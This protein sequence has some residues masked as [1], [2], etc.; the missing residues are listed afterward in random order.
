MSFLDVI[1]FNIA[2]VYSDQEQY[3]KAIEALE[4]ELLINREMHDRPSEA[5]TLHT[6]ANQ[7]ENLSQYSQALERYQQALVIYRELQNQEREVVALWSIGSIYLA[8]GQ[9]P[10]A[11]EQYQQALSI[12]QAQNYPGAEA[13]SLIKIGQ[14]YDAQGQ[15]A[16][17]LTQY[18]Q[19]LNTHRQIQQQLQ[20]PDAIDRLNAICSYVPQY[21]PQTS[22][23]L[24]GYSQNLY[25][26]FLEFSR[27]DCL[28]TSRYVESAALHSIGLVYRAQGRYSEAMNLLQ[29]SLTISVEY[30]DPSEQAPTLL[31]IGN[32][33][34][35]QGQYTQ[36]LDYYQ[37]A[38]TI[39]QNAGIRYGESVTLNSMSTVYEAQGQYAQALETNQQSIDIAR[40]I[41]NARLVQADAV[42][43]LGTTYDRLGQY[44]Q[45]LK[46][47]QQALTTYREIGNRNS[48]AVALDD[49][50]D[51]YRKQNQPDRA[52]EQ[53]QQALAIWQEIGAVAQESNTLRN[54]GLVYQM[55]GQIDRSIPLFQQAI[56]IQR[57][58]GA[59][60]SIGYTLQGLGLAYQQQGNADGAIE[61]FQQAL[62]THRETGDRSGEAQVLSDLGAAYWRSSQLPQAESTL[63]AAMTMLESL[64]ASELNDSDTIAL[65]DTQEATY[66][67]LQQVLIAQNKIAPA[68]EIAE[69]GRA[70]AFV[71]LLASELSD[72]LATAI[73]Q[74]APNLAAIQRI[75]QQHNATLVNYSIIT[76]EAHKPSLYIWVV[77]PTGAIYF[78]SVNLAMLDRPLD[79]L[80]SIS[81]QSIGARSR[82]PGTVVAAL[83]PEAQERDRLQ[84]RQNLQ[85]L[86]QLLIESIATYLPSSPEEQVIFVPQGELFLVPFPALINRTGSYLIE[87]HTISS[88]PSIQVLDFTYQQRQTYRSD[89]PSD[90]SPADVLVVGNP[91][92]PSIINPVDG[93][94]QQLS[95]LPATEAEAAAIAQ[96]FHTQPLLWE[97]ASEPVVAERMQTARLIHLA[98]HGLLEYG[99]P[100]DSGVQDFPGAIALAAANDA[101][102]LLTAAEIRQ[103]HLNAELVILSA[104]DTGRGRISGD[105]VIGLSRSLISAGVPSIIV[106]LW[107]VPDAPTAELMIE[108][109]RQW[110]H[111]PD[112]AQA[113]RQ[114]ML[115]TMQT[116][117]NPRDWAAFTLI[118]EAQ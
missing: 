22:G 46:L 93:R 30:N 75:A 89:R 108:F 55:Q 115:T 47:H 100:Q 41:P 43:F 66:Q 7:Y 116:H 67:T 32:V 39:Y 112:K 65:V 19:A 38:L 80:V 42:S 54:I 60:S 8:W 64:R 73:D 3:Q 56:E 76:S 53:Y 105:G 12:A 26:Q 63:Y 97:Q 69:R 1:Y 25:R 87:Q 74:T 27:S 45:A 68:L 110:Q 70:R 109:Y 84:Q 103:M 33:Y 57:S 24:V 98:T 20:Q 59:R 82:T 83:T 2:N 99:S 52:L 18:Q 58:I 6:I 16:L 9:Y 92:M 48:E 28:K 15:Y 34:I 72:R 61:L 107:S 88:A 102:G 81:R 11:L 10:D 118:G 104:C 113:L 85:Q 36:A 86:Y 49:I 90:L 35:S 21:T 114:A 17:A 40:S 96:S 91:I 4:Q 101:D 117:P 51:I 13:T 5:G 23:D 77:Q 106:S 71:K 79:E 78:Q 62:A 37:Q 50:G 94:S 14:V 95:S 31:E 111:N 44:E 29:Q